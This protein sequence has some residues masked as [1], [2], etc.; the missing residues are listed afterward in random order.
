MRE[1]AHH[2]SRLKTQGRDRGSGRNGPT[3]RH[4]LS[5]RVRGRLRSA[6]DAGIHGSRRDMPPRPS[7][8]MA[9]TGAQR[10]EANGGAPRQ[11]KKA[12]TPTGRDPRPRLPVPERTPSGKVLAGGFRAAIAPRTALSGSHLERRSGTGGRGCRRSLTR[13]AASVICRPGM[14]TAPHGSETGGGIGSIALRS[15]LP[16]LP[17]VGGRETPEGTE[18]T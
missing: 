10:V 4:Q 3:K 13:G 5:I 12:G 14:D 1:H 18:Q 2:G 16:L 9:R 6:C 15:R 11:E 8:A 7:A 17:Y